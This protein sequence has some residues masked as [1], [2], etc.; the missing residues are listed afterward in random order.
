MNYVTER[1]K[2][3]K[4]CF[5]AEDPYVQG[6]AECMRVLKLELKRREK[7]K[8]EQTEVEEC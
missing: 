6:Y 1:Y 4:L 3:L 2:H 8:G 5:G 7:N